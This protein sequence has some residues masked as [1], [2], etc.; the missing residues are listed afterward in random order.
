M[1]QR[2][3]FIVVLLLFVTAGTAWARTGSWGAVERLNPGTAIWVKAGH[4]VRCV[5][6]RATAK[7]LVC[8]P[9]GPLPAWMGRLTYR[10]DRRT[11][12]EVRLKLSDA[13]NALVGTAIGAGTG[14]AI[15]AVSA[16]NSTSRGG[17]ALFGALLCGVIGH[18][19]GRVAPI[20]HGKVVYKR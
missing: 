20:F 8:D 5:F 1:N 4:H 18:V 3:I 2:R 16:G 10:F 7:E 11:V 15:G 17:G 12:R 9:I 13:T 6:V 14:A 19:L